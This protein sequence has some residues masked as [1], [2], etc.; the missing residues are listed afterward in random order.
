MLAF[1]V[2]IYHSI[3]G[4]TKRKNTEPVASTSAAKV[5]S[6]SFPLT[7]SPTAFD[8]LEAF[9]VCNDLQAFLSQS[10]LSSTSHI[11]KFKQMDFYMGP[12]ARAVDRTMWVRKY[13]NDYTQQ[14]EVHWMR[15][16]LGRDGRAIGLPSRQKLS[17][18][19]VP[20]SAPELKT[21]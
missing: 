6:T 7:L 9:P 4:R 2:S 13:L 8:L 21:S 5:P 19:F 18:F 10:S 16:N 3:M 1:P 12:E 17:D 14:Y 11:P 20:N 15:E